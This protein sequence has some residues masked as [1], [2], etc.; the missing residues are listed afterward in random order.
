LKRELL[1]IVSVSSHF[2]TIGVQLVKQKDR[3]VKLVF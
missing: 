1:L 3:L 2:A